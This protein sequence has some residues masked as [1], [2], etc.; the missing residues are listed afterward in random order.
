MS[1][2]RLSTQSHCLHIASV[3]DGGH[4]VVIERDF[5]GRARDI[6]EITADCMVGVPQVAWRRHLAALSQITRLV[7]RL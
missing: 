7:T 3:G 2:R 6:T 4:V 1:T 5:A